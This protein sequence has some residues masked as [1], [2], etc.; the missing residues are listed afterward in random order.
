MGAHAKRSCRQLGKGRVAGRILDQAG[1]YAV[2]H[3]L[4]KRLF[5][6]TAAASGNQFLAGGGIDMLEHA[7]AVADLGD[8]NHL[9]I[10]VL[11]QLLQDQAHAFIDQFVASICRG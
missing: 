8:K 9:H 10:E 1:Q 7:L 5:Q 11:A 3:A 2:E 4:A 6:G